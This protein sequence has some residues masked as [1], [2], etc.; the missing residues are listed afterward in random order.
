MRFA[1]FYKNNMSTPK[2]IAI[3][4]DGNGRWAK[5]RHLPKI[6]G[7]KR[8][9]ETVK[10]IIKACVRLK[11]K[12]LTLYTFST[13]NWNRPTKEVRAL[14]KLLD[15]FLNSQTR[16]FHDNKVRFCVI[17]ERE[18]IDET[19]RGKIEKLERDTKGYDALLVN[20]ALSYGSRQEI[21]S[22]V[23]SIAEKV[24]GGILK[25]DEIDENIFSNHLYTRGCPDPDL[26]IRTS[27]EMRISNFLLWQISYAEIYVIEKLWPDFSEEDLEK[28]IEEYKRRERKFGR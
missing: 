12:Y 27:G 23:R 17:G 20:V 8:G 9:V 26:L 6:M 4:M 10:K 1:F 3:I 19:L 18:R 11:V 28:A 2:H 15:Q 22:A 5:K 14:F 25:L 13:E 7:H 24:E 16:L 21:V